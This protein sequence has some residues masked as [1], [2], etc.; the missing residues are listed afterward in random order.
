MDLFDVLVKTGNSID[1]IST[2]C[3]SYSTCCAASCECFLCKRTRD[4]KTVRIIRVFF[5]AYRDG[6]TQKL[7]PQEK[8]APGEALVNICVCVW[9]IESKIIP[10]KRTLGGLLWRSDP[11]FRL[12]YFPKWSL[13]I[14]KEALMEGGIGIWKQRKGN[15]SLLTLNLLFSSDILCSTLSLLN[16]HT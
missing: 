3:V 11:L 12:D 14:H 10:L 5:W 1:L 7:F 6:S 15:H 9:K 2:R 13:N 16:K 8:L 4:W